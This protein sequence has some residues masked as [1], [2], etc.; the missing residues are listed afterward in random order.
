LNRGFLLELAGQ[1]TVGQEH[2]P[3]LDPNEGTGETA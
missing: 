1:N 3:Q 2:R